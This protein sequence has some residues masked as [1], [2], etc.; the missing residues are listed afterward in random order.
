MFH[1][2]GH[3]FER[4]IAIAESTRE[5]ARVPRAPIRRFPWFAIRILAPFV[6]T[7]REMLEMRYLWKKPLKLDNRKLVA[8]LGREPHTPIDTA[9]Q[10]TLTGLG[11]MPS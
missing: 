2:G 6:E 8:F 1:F 11:C 7:F 4:G 9:L 3:W 5:A 10:D